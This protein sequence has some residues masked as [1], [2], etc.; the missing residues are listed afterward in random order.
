MEQLQGWVAEGWIRTTPGDVLDIEAVREDLRADLAL[1]DVRE[2][3]F[4]PWALSQFAGEMMTEGAPMVEVRS[5]VQNFSEP[6]KRLDAMVA[7]RE[8]EHQADPV[9][10]WM[11]S[12]VV[13]HRDV[14]DNIYPRKERDDSKIDAAVGLIMAIGRAF[15][16]RE[17]SAEPLIVVLG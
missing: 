8:L 5:N 9:L 17:E 6:M 4:D 10:A 7:G 1:F 12:N 2:V 14:K 15:A 3:A 16:P 13:C 11:I